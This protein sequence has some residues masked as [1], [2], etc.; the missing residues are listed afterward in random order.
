MPGFLVRFYHD[1]Q[2]HVMGEVAPSPLQA[3]LAD[4][5]EVLRR[6][7]DWLE[8]L[9]RGAEV[10]VNLRPETDAETKYVW[11]YRPRMRR[12][13]ARIISD[14]EELTAYPSGTAEERA[15]DDEARRVQHRHRLAKP[16]PSSKPLTARQERAALREVL[17]LPLHVRM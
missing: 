13:L 7:R 3:C 6:C 12:V 16:D 11:F 5:V 9:K 17:G 8:R 4:E 14:L 1:L 10:V 15:L 2:S